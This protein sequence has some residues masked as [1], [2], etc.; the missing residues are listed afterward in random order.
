MFWLIRCNVI[1]VYKFK[2]LYLIIGYWFINFKFVFLFKMMKD[3]ENYR[4][5]NLFCCILIF[6]DLV[7]VFCFVMFFFYLFLCLNSFCCFWN[8][9]FLSFVIFCLKFF[10]LVCNWVIV[11]FFFCNEIKVVFDIVVLFWLCIILFLC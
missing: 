7:C 3:E 2:Y 1:L 4:K 5:W 11:W 6:K 9:W 8:S 10:K